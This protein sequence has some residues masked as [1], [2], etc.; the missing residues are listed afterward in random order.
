MDLSAGLPIVNV[1]LP[2]G[3][4]TMWAVADPPPGWLICD[5][6]AFMLGSIQSW[7]Q[8]L[9]VTN[10]PDLRGQFIRG[11]VAQRTHPKQSGAVD[12]RARP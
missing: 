3:T 6:Q 11:A 5:G 2:I 8:V 10:V 12:D 1:G 4:I 7:Q 9:G